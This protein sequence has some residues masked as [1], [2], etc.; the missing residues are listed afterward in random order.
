[1]ATPAAVR[2]A[3]AGHDAC[4]A[5][6][7]RRTREQRRRARLSIV[8]AHPRDL[9]AVVPQVETACRREAG[10]RGAPGQLRSG[11]SGWRAHAVR[12]WRRDRPADP[13][14]IS[15]GDACCDRAATAR[16][17]ADAVF[18]APTNRNR[19]W[20]Q[21]RQRFRHKSAGKPLD[22]LPNAER[23]KW[24]PAF[25]AR[26][27]DTECFQEQLRLAGPLLEEIAFRRQHGVLRWDRGTLPGRFTDRKTSL[28]TVA[29][30][31]AARLQIA[32]LIRAVVPQSR[33]EPSLHGAAS[34]RS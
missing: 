34:A 9:G 24:Y 22:E 15:A 8:A 33:T 20:R 25:Y 18:T 11:R 28:F 30:S 26:P 2:C 12:R 7:A 6:S 27:L 1:M 14:H 13:S 10:R 31:F 32:S 29:Q 16:G 23:V 17:G 21:G 19:L 4:D 3:V 5:G